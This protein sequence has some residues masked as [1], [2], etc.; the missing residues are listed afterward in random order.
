[1]R[2]LAVIA[3]VALTGC[4]SLPDM[5]DGTGLPLG[6]TGW[7][8]SG[9]ADFEKKVWFV[10]FTRPWGERESKVAEYFGK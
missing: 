5:G 9:G 10:L 4:A 6:K 8:L 1:M 7:Q 3:A 2:L